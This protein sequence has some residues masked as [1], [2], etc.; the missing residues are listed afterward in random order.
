MLPM[1]RWRTADSGDSTA[2]EVHTE[3]A[4]H[5]VAVGGSGAAHGWYH[6]QSAQQLRVKYALLLSLHCT[7]LL[8]G[9]L[10]DHAAGT[11][12]MCDWEFCSVMRN[13]APVNSTAEIA[14]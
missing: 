14:V 1:P 12:I 11:S 5:S 8:P 4:L 10:S 13:P 9:H 2:D 6:S 7:A 3:A